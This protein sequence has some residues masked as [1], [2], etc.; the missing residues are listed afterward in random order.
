MF[1]LML[2]QECCNPVPGNS[3]VNGKMYQGVCLS[4][5][6]LISCKIW[7][8]ISPYLTLTC[9]LSHISSHAWI[10][11]IK[12]KLQLLCCLF[13][14]R[15]VSRSHFQAPASLGPT[16]SQDTPLTPPCNLQAQNRG[17]IMYRTYIL[18]IYPGYLSS[19]DQ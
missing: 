3:F 1:S 19:W 18:I 17:R 10:S 2:M 13:P 4:L 5:I 9:V 7:Q 11:I 8:D 16:P 15:I 6:T 12:K 14:A